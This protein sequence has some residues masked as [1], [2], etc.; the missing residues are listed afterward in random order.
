MRVLIF[1]SS[2]TQ[3]FWDLDGG[4]ATRIRRHY[5]EKSMQDLENDNE[6]TIFNLGVSADTSQNIVERFESET[7]ARTR[8]NIKPVTVVEIGINDSMLEAGQEKVSLEDYKKNLELIIE[9]AERVST[10]LLFVGL[11]ACDETITTPVLWGDYVYT[12][13]RIK[14]YEQAM[15][16]VADSHNLTFIPV[17]EEF[18]AQ[19]KSGNNLLADGLHPNASGHQIIT[20][21]VLPVLQSQLAKL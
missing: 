21:L 10:Q 11:S 7:I 8:H 4:W 3:G 16:E 14:M 18:Y 17:F 15:K 12:N 19:I 13:E 2:I 5:D 6:P 20:D 1:G 9:A